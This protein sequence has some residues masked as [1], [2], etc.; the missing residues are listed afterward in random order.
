MPYLTIDKDGKET[1]FAGRP[2]KEIFKENKSNDIEIW[3]EDQP[4]HFDYGHCDLPKGTI[5]RIIGRKLHIDECFWLNQEEQI[6]KAI[7][8][9]ENYT[10]YEY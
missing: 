2:K 7:E 10:K 1:M 8:H 5:E 6:D 9:Y 4:G 3:I